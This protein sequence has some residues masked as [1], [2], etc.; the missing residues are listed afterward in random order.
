MKNAFVVSFFLLLG[1]IYFSFYSLMPQTISS[2]TMATMLSNS[3]A[4]AIVKEAAKVKAK[5]K[6]KPKLAPKPH[7]L[8][9]FIVACNSFHNVSHGYF[10]AGSQLFVSLSEALQR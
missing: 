7:L 9:V 5:P 8:S 2:L 6:P 10:F 4:A 1:L 3:C